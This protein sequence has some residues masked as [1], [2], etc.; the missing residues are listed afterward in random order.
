MIDSSQKKRGGAYNLSRAVLAGVLAAGCL[1]PGFAEAAKFHMDG[2]TKGTDY[3]EVGNTATITAVNGNAGGTIKIYWEPGAGETVVKG[4][5][6]N[7]NPITI[8]PNINIYGGYSSSGEANGNRVSISNG[9][10]DNVYGG[11]SSSGEANGNRV[12]ISNGEFDNVYGGYSSSGEANNNS[13]IISG[14]KVM[15][16][17]RGGESDQ[18]TAN[19]NSVIISGGEFDDIYCG[20]KRLKRCRRLR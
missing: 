8:E 12:S 9:E 10:F 17:V 3:T 14:G 20:R 11:Y 2:G 6:I 1:M 19:E 15:D 16:D 7:V 18:G 5:T 4:C 13:V